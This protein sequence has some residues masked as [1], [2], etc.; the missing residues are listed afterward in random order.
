MNVGSNSDTAL[1]LRK[2]EVQDRLVE[3]KDSD[4]YSNWNDIKTKFDKE[5]NSQVS[6]SALKTAYNRTI[7]TNI[8]ISGP[9][10][11][12][13]KN[14]T[15]NMETRMN[16]IMSMA[17]IL[18]VEFQ[19]TIDWLKDADELEPVQRM[20]LMG[21]IIRSYESLSNSF[22]KQI[23]L[24]TSQLEQVKIEQTKM[25]W[26]EAKVHEELNKLLPN[27]LKALEE[28]DENGNQ[29]IIVM[30]RNLLNE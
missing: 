4:K 15:D 21:N 5:F 16:N 30:D 1:L 25:Q 8:T 19:K 27:M 2:P 3:L 12:P 24:V 26:T 23:T 18:A 13:L 6:V 22:M 20:N 11:N 14:L 9:K 10:N 17:D 7:A 28:P 29:K